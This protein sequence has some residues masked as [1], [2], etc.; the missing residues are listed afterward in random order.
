MKFKIGDKVN[1]KRYGP[2]VILNIDEKDT[3]CPYYVEVLIYPREGKPFK[4]GQWTVGKVT[5]LK[6]ETYLQEEE[7]YINKK[8]IYKKIDLE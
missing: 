1:T 6:G 3:E 7:N 5:A 2:G 4:V 8:K